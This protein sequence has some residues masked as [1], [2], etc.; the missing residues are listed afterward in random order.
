MGF[1]SGFKGLI[2]TFRRTTLGRTPREEGSVRRRD[3]YLT[4]HNT[5]KR[6]ISMTPAAFQPTILPPDPTHRQTHIHSVGL[7]WMRDRSVAETS[8]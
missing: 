4:T 5:H 6:Q 8:T 2:I 3:L 7:P 1:N